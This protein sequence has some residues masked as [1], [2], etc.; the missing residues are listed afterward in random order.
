MAVYTDV[1]FGQAA[2]LLSDLGLG[3]LLSLKGIESGIENTNYFATSDQGDWVLTVFERLSADELPYFLELKRHLGHGGLL[4]PVPQGSSAGRLVHQISN[5]PAAVVSRLQGR[6]ET[7]PGVDHCRQVGLFLAQM[8]RIG[9]S[10]Q[11]RQDHSR[12][13][14]WCAT[15][16]PQIKPFVGAEVS[17]LLD[18]ELAHLQ[19]VAAS[20]A[21]QALPR[22]HIHADLFR[23]NA[24]FIESNDGPRLSGVLDF[25]FA[26]V[27]VLLFDVAVCINDWCVDDATGRIDSKR[28]L[29]LVTAYRSQREWEPDECRLLPSLLQA[30]A[31]RFWLS[32]LW[33][34]HLPRAA[35]LLKPKDPTHFE[36]VLKDRIAHPW[37]P[38]P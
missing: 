4:V 25:Y 27:D 38:Q 36:R 29:A 12:G 14:P 18:S 22:G 35:S 3:R 11:P 19:A 5:K 28:A 30:A 9:Q 17:A 15:V 26:G 20:P 16:V 21:G 6:P 34:W 7:K 8:H 13:W 1:E 32:R 23:D 31:F 2:K 10:F 24:M 37:A 33:D